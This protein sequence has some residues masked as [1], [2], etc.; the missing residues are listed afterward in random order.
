MSPH[1]N[2]HTRPG[3]NIGLRYVGEGIRILGFDKLKS[4]SFIWRDCV[5]RCKARC[6][7]RRRRM[8]Y[9]DK[10]MRKSKTIC[11]IVQLKDQF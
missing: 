11:I 2:R 10:R 5:E 8:K 7:C 6:V 3:Y 9:I 4:L 1:S